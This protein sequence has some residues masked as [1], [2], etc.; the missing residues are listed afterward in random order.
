MIFKVI[1]D[2]HPRSHYL[3][4]VK[5]HPEPK[6]DRRLFGRT[7][8]QNSLV[9][10]SFGILADRPECY[11][12]SDVVGCVVTGLPREHVA[13]H[14]SCRQGLAAIY[15][16][17][18]RVEQARAGKDLLAILE[19]VVESGWTD[20]FAVKARFWSA[21]STSTLISISCATGR[22]GTRPLKSCSRMRP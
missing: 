19:G 13:V 3:G 16:Q 4:Y 17:P 10:K 11:V 18:G 12:Y 22:A 1:G 6:G 8:R 21:A 7:Y 20:L 15:E 9:S 5:Y 14:Y 2:V